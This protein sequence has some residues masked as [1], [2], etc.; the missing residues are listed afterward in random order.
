MEMLLFKSMV[1]ESL[2]YFTCRDKNLL[3]MKSY[4]FGAY[5]LGLRNLLL[6]TGDP[7]QIGEHSDATAIY[8]VD[9]IG[10]ANMVSRLNGGVDVGGKSIGKPTGFVIGVGANPGAMSDLELKRFF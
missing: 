4:L 5:A 10:L 8:E 1:I 2:A 7:H 9:S 3:G 6:I